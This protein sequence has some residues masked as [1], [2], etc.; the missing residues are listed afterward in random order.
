M[1][2]YTMK[3]VTSAL[4][5]KRCHATAAAGPA[6]GAEPSAVSLQRGRSFVSAE[7]RLAAC[8][9]LR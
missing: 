5:V 8:E 9:R 3:C 6:R 7:A 4:F 2:C 1:V